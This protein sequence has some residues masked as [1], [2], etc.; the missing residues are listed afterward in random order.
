MILMEKGINLYYGYKLSEKEMIDNFFDL[1]FRQYVEDIYK[2]TPSIRLN[3][4]E[5]NK[6]EHI[7]DLVRELFITY[8]NKDFFFANGYKAPI[9]V[10]CNKCCLYDTDSS[11]VV[12]IKICHMPAFKNKISMIS[13][14][15]ITESDI[16]GLS[17]LNKNFNLQKLVPIFLSI[18]SDCW[19]CT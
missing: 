9:K 17:R 16:N 3:F 19:S 14:H 10:C 18:P 6:M 4:D 8:Y 2:M 5:S 1:D 13:G 15:I 12:G 7:D 11:W